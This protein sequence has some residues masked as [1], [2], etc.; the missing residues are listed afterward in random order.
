MNF[1]PAIKRKLLI[2]LFLLSVLTFNIYSEETT[3]KIVV[4]EETGQIVLAVVDVDESI[5]G[6]FVRL[7]S[8]DR[9][10][11]WVA[12]IGWSCRN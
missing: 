5:L 12:P 1:K 10:I 4:L 6:V 2:L 11:R 3:I 8:S 7:L 9:T